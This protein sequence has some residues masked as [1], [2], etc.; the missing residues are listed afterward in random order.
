MSNESG[1]SSSLETF[2]KLSETIIVHSR[3]HRFGRNVT[4]ESMWQYTER[5]AEEAEE[6]QVFGDICDEFLNA[7]AHLLDLQA[8]PLETGYLRLIRLLRKWQHS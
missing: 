7:G 5:L 2:F 6:F 3:S 8:M 4:P 1:E